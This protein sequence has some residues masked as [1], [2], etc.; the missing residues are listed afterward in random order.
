[1]QAVL[2]PCA[3][4]WSTYR[5]STGLRPG[6]CGNASCR[7]HGFGVFLSSRSRLF[8]HS[9]VFSHQ[10]GGAISAYCGWAIAGLG[11]Q[12]RVWGSLGKREESEGLT[13][14]Q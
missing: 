1:M 11:A 14:V 9:A 3:L 6:C 7:A 10:G 12:R 8:R 4:F 2:T 5:L 13:A